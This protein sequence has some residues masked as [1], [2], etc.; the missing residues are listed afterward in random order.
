[1]T[2]AQRTAVKN[3][4]LLGYRL[5]YTDSRNGYAYVSKAYNN[6]LDIVIPIDRHGIS[7][8]GRSRDRRLEQSA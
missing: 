8:R 4:E 3:F 1:M 2:R 5:E 7:H 6:R